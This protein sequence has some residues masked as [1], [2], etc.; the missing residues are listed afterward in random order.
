MAAKQCPRLSTALFARI[1]ALLALLAVAMA[2]AATPVMAQSAGVTLDPTSA[3]LAY[4]ES[5]QF[6]AVVSG[7]NN[8]RV[9]WEVLDRRGAPTTEGGS[10]TAEGL[11]TAPAADGV[12]Y[13]RA[14]S[15][16]DGS[17]SALAQVVVSA[18]GRN[19]VL[20][21][22][23]DFD[24][25]TATTIADVNG[26]GV[27]DYRQNVTPASGDPSPA[28]ANAGAGLAAGQLMIT[29]DGDNQL[30]TEKST[31]V[32]VVADAASAYPGAFDSNALLFFDGHPGGTSVSP[33]YPEFPSF[34]VD[35]GAP[36]VA[37][38]FSVRFY[39]PGAG[40]AGLT[41]Q[42]GSAWNSGTDYRL[43]GSARAADI[44]LAGGKVTGQ[45][46]GAT[47]GLTYSP[48]AIH[49]LTIRF[50]KSDTSKG[51]GG[52]YSFQIDDG[53]VGT[54][55]YVNAVDPDRFSIHNGS[56]VNLTPEFLLD[57][58]AVAAV[59]AAS[60]S[61]P[62]SEVVQASVDWNDV[63]GVT[64]GESFGLNG[65]S[66]MA[67]AI[68]A[69]ER[70]GANMA[71]MNAGL[72]RIHYAGLLND[73]A[74]DARGWADVETQSWDRER[75]ATVF[76]E[77]ASWQAR[78]GYAPDIMISIPSWPSWMQ[79]YGVT[80]ARTNGGTKT[81][82]GFL[83]PDAYDDYAA[84]CAELARILNVEMGLNVKYFEVTNER[85]DLYYVQ[86]Q[87]TVG[88]D[89]LD[90]LVTIYNTAT[91]AIKAVDPS[92][93]VGGPAFARGDLVDQVRRFVRGAKHNLDF[94]SYH[95]YA[96][97]NL[98][99]SDRQILY[100]RVA[101]LERHS[102]DIMQIVAEESP[103]RAIP[104]HLN[105]YNISWTFQN[106]DPRMQSYKGAIFDALIMVAAANTGNAATNAWNER[107]G[108]YGKMDGNSELR[109]TGHTFQLFNS[110]LRGSRVAVASSSEDVV[111]LA[112][113]D[114]ATGRRSILVINR[115]PSIQQVAIDFK[116][117]SPGSYALD[118]FEI[119]ETG[120]YAGTIDGKALRK[121]DLYVPPLSVTVITVAGLE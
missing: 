70:Y 119:A 10:I 47:T 21:Y 16:V 5:V 2:G 24:R 86:F 11:Y 60:V 89:K 79:T 105:E 9:S 77:V 101:D 66:L 32:D 18:T 52:T 102:R 98:N 41:V 109:V 19:P 20:K 107:D 76:A 104:V 50:D 81:I 61:P 95:F 106:N 82:N 62:P 65:Y 35:F 68:I 49:T 114:K 42:L 78:Y 97:G 120:Y 38:S 22:R 85:D 30:P 74:R 84:F 4:G 23:N 57:D 43:G 96:S 44:Q 59:E 54:A 115:S 80:V 83:H 28:N 55:G 51:P 103:E 91:E 118:R 39:D 113:E 90:E 67:P 72:L 93:Q 46:A 73:S 64:T 17:A 56:L 37:G 94:L 27:P 3:V 108:I 29:H 112:V 26:D 71:T 53:P 100:N 14:R 12:F 15:G 25:D 13:V 45:G 69:E 110:Y 92:I 31:Q 36:T 48:G 75:I 88:P 1:V 8:T 33:R 99:D 34:A 121:G 63:R 40:G 111:L 6:S 116:G 87:G 7:I 117:W 58:I